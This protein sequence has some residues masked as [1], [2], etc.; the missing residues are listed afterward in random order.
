MSVGSFL[1]YGEDVCV[2]PRGGGGRRRMKRRNVDLRVDDG[3]RIIHRDAEGRTREYKRVEE[4]GDAEKYRSR[5]RT[6]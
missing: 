3:G 1:T 5:G 4:Q 2:K 6:Y